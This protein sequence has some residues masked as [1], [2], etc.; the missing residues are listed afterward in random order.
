MDD[1]KM[2]L[3]S[4]FIIFFWTINCFATGQTGE[5]IIYKGDTLTMLCEPLETFL[6][7]HEPREKFHP[8]LK[9]GCSTALWRGYVGL[10]EIKEDRLFLIDVFACGDRKQSIKENIFKGQPSKIPAEWYTGPLFIEKGKVIRYNHM[11]YDRHY[12]TEFI[13]S[14][15]DG[16]VENEMEYKNGVSPEDKRF[17]RKPED[18]QEQIYK[19]INWDKLPELS[20]EKKLYV[21]I[22]VNG[23][24]EIGESEIKGHLEGEYRNQLE[25]I[26]RDFPLV[27][28]FYSRG[29]PL[30]EGWTIPIF[31]TKESKKRY[32]R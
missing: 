14:V 31:F 19:Q 12:E 24:G 17:S 7:K 2:R 30:N 26:I 25:Q 10:W 23:N 29:E 16:K 20:K 13:V 4:T 5:L 15:K 8:F 1:R 27:Q 11:G 6:Q 21:T 9:D 22:K 32:A 3:A 18:I 28:V